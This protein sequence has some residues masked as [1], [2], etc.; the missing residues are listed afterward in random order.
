MANSYFFKQVFDFKV[1][2]GC[3]QELQIKGERVEHLASQR[4]FCWARTALD[5]ERLRKFR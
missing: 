5:F 3:M 2:K 1:F 4:S